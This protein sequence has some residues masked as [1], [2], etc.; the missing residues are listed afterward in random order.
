MR[1]EKVII[2]LIYALMKESSMLAEIYDLVDREKVE[3]WPNVVN[4]NYTIDEAYL[5]LIHFLK[6]KSIRG[7]V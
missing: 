7:L 1:L 5:F 3:S 4:G 2:G 6:E